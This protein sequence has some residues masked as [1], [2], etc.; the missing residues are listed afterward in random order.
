MGSEIAQGREWRYEHS[1]DWHEWNDKGR[2]LCFKWLCDLL[3][4]YKTHPAL[5]MGD[6]EPW[7]FQWIDCQ[8]QDDAIVVFIR[9]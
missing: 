6:D 8:T 7:N 1:I 3:K 5:Y 2:Q 9:Y 4:V